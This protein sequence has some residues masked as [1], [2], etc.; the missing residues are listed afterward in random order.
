MPGSAG[1][2]LEAGSGPL[3]A[4]LVTTTMASTSLVANGVPAGTYYVRV[5]ALFVGIIRP[6]F[7]T[8]TVSNELVVIVP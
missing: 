1:Y 2:Q 7:F 6:T 4:N 5:R 8:S 3:L